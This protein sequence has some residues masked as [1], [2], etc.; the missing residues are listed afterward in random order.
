[1]HR[2]IVNPTIRGSYI[3]LLIFIGGA[4][5]S[6]CVGGVGAAGAVAAAGK[7]LA[8]FAIFPARVPPSAPVVA[9]VKRRRSF[10]IVVFLTLNCLFISLVR[11]QG[12]FSGN[13]GKYGR[14]VGIH[15]CRCI[16]MIT[17]I[18]ICIY[19][20]LSISISISIS[21]LIRINIGTGIGICSIKGIYISIDTRGNQGNGKDNDANTINIIITNATNNKAQQQQQHDD[22]DNDNGNGDKN[23]GNINDND[24]NG[25]NSDNDNNNDYYISSSTR[26]I[27]IST[28][29]FSS[30]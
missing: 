22:N 27:L 26:S 7:Y 1:M 5:G 25:D 19:I 11:R 2:G 18:G 15:T 8:M 13:H 28:A 29:V 24:D 17:N 10:V 20:S 14:L 4:G 3:L 12:W 23:Y 21:I 6:R 30:T 9:F 16:N